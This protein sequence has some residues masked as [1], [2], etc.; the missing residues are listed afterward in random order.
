[1]FH[2]RLYIA[3]C[4]MGIFYSL[5]TGYPEPPDV[6]N[7]N[8]LLGRT[9]DIETCQEALSTMSRGRATGLISIFT[10]QS[11]ARGLTRVPLIFTASAR[12]SLCVI[13]IDLDGHSQNE[14]TVT[15]PWDV[16]RQVTQALIDKC[17]SRS[18]SGII[19]YGLGTTLNAL[20]T[21]VAYSGLS[22]DLTAF[23]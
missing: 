20:M 13:T 5:T 8:R 16:V 6:S 22:I 3:L 2:M 12:R 7:C 21:P 1:M 11:S 9:L 18:I 15:V 19:T 23:V 4:A 10:T 14:D 17:A